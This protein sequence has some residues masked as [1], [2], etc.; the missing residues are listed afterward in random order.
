MKK[1]KNISRD[2]NKRFKVITDKYSLNKV[3]VVAIEISKFNSKGTI[4]NM[5]A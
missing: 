4:A 1:I 3:L 2:G 5:L